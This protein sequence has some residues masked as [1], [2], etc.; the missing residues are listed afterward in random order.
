[1]SSELEGEVIS[2]GKRWGSILLSVPAVL[3][4]L[5]PSLTCPLCWPGYVAI[6]S[7]LGLGF[8]ATSAY[9]L[10]LT[11]IL[12]GLAMAGLAIQGSRSG[13]YGPLLLSLVSSAAIVSGKFLLGSASLVYIGVAALIGASGWS[14]LKRHRSPA[15]E[16]SDCADH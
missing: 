14:L 8:L 5:L 16:C 1:M 3:V 11:L 6:L 10:P 2:G 9:L 12:L 4:S 7:A 13:Q 15:P